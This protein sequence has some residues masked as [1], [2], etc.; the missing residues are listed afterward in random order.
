LI[1][2]WQDLSVDLPRGRNYL[3]RADAVRHGVDANDPHALADGPALR[4][5]V[6]DLVHWAGSLMVEGAE[7]PLRVPGRAGWELRLVLHGGWRILER[8]AL[9]DCAT[10][11]R[12]PRL[13][14]CDLPLL[15]W[16]SWRY[17]AAWFAPGRL[18]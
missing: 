7:L 18:A 10:I 15:A 9:M 16:R 2:F 12:R 11:V 4:A 5:L 6:R 13:L 3:P 17:R 1:N 14:A 8:I